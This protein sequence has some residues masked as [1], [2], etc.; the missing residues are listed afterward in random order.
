MAEPRTKLLIADA[1]VLLR[2][3]RLGVF[4]FLRDIRRELDLEIAITA[5]VLY[6]IGLEID[7][8]Q[9]AACGVT[10]RRQSAAVT[11]RAQEMRERGEI[12]RRLSETDAEMLVLGLTDGFTIWT[13]DDRLFKT[14]QKKGVKAI[15]LFNPFCRLVEMGCITAESVIEL[16]MRLVGLDERFTERDLKSLKDRLNGR[17][18]TP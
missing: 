10:I 14:A 9:L 12:S 7:E 2:L 5:S 8:S 18:A 17:N 4:A 6:E 3:Q 1:S 11:A 15:H 16:G 13:D